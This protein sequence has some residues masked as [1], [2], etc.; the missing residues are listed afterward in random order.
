L[1]CGRVE[2]RN[3]DVSGRRTNERQGER[4]ALVREC[5]SYREGD[6]KAV[7]LEA[8]RG[9]CYDADSLKRCMLANG[10]TRRRWIWA[11]YK[12]QSRYRDHCV[13]F[14]LYTFSRVFADVLS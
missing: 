5:V 6:G 7:R 14:L 9:S 13:A 8:D 1:I 10:V 4:S 12:V 3:G 2:E 11:M